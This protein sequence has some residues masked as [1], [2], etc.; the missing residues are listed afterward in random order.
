M[1]EYK[2]ED[3]VKPPQP[4]MGNPLKYPFDKM[5][6]GQ[7]FRVA[8]LEDPTGAKIRKAASSYHRRHPEYRFRVAVDKCGADSGWRVWRVDGSEVMARKTLAYPRSFSAADIAEMEAKRKAAAM[9][10]A[11][12]EDDNGQAEYE[13]QKAAD[14]AELRAEKVSAARKEVV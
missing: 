2:I 3:N 8:I 9:K 11:D 12:D 13:R 4:K 6:V 10:H 1:S 5:G 7:S 14:L